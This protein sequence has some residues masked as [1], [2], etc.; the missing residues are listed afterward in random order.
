MAA[1][2]QEDGRGYLA[3]SSSPQR[4]SGWIG[5]GWFPGRLGKLNPEA[6]CWAWRVSKF[7]SLINRALIGAD[8]G[9]PPLPPSDPAPGGG[10]GDYA[11]S[12]PFHF[13]PLLSFSSVNQLLVLVHVFLFQIM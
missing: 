4:H 10:G 13:F 2:E 9:G 7:A 3:A 1:N 8:C 5:P 12:F 11:V 6:D